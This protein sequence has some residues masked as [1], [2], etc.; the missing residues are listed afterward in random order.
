MPLPTP[1]YAQQVAACESNEWRNWSGYMGPSLYEPTHEREYYAVRNS[2]GL[3]DISPLYKYAITGADATLLLNRVMTRDMGRCRVGQVVYSPWC[4]EAGDMIQD[5]NIMRLAE[6]EYLLS[7]AEPT[8]RWLQDCGY[9]MDVQ[10]ADVSQN[11]AALALQGP[12]ARLILQELV[13]GLDLEK[14]RYFRCGQAQVADFSLWVSRTGFTGDLG[15][16][17]WVAPDHAEALWDLLMDRG[18]AYGILPVGLAVLDM[19]R[20]EAGLL[21]IDVDYIAA[22]HAVI[23]AQKSSPLE[24]GLGWA[25]DFKKD[26]FVGRRALLAQ[27]ESGPDWSFVGLEVGWAELDRLYA[28]VDLRPT[29]VGQGTSRQ[30]VPVYRQ[31]SAS[32]HQIGQATSHLYSPLLKKYIAL[33]TLRQEDA[34]VGKTVDLEMT[35]EFSHVLAQATI[36]KLPFFDPPRKRKP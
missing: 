22:H 34:Q 35:V 25:V 36:V 10:V 13:Q 17:L 23:D 27:Q 28:E 2:A 9:G 11:W 32:T 16:E 26:N 3:L 5:G 7:A 18:A 24:A 19:V 21:L 15:Y 1:F 29:V 20:V 12:K 8:L 14:L 30:A 31:G 4:D 33:A 6:Q